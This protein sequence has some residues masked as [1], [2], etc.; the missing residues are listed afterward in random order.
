MYTWSDIATRTE[1][2][3][4]SAM[5]RP[6]PDYADRFAAYSSRCGAVFGKI[7]CMVVA[8][9]WLF[10]CLL[11]WLW[12]ASGI[13]RV[14]AFEQGRMEKVRVWREFGCVNHSR[15]FLRRE[16]TREETSN[17]GDE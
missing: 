10:L 14:P 12:P 4:A 11:E 15:Q 7:M 16:Q 17:R 6:H 8:V 3:Y 5:A 9:D 13:D 2:V 1:A